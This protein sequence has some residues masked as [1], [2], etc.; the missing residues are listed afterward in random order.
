MIRRVFYCRGVQRAA[1][2]RHG[3]G[4]VL[5]VERWRFRANQATRRGGGHGRGGDVRMHRV[6]RLPTGRSRAVT[7][8]FK[9]RRHVGDV[10]DRR[11]GGRRKGRRARVRHGDDWRRL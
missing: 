7:R 6:D 5:R 8:H 2:S 4:N 1:G 11:G 10:S 9:R 3:G